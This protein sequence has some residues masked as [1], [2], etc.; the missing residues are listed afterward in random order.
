MWGGYRHWDDC[1]D[2]LSLFICLIKSIVTFQ[3]CGNYFMSSACN[4]NET[5]ECFMK[6][7]IQ[8]LHPRDSGSGSLVGLLVLT[9]VDFG[10]YNGGST[11]MV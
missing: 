6:R 11:G 3:T 2:F 10:P 1:C 4:R 7:V 8:N 9:S 5:H